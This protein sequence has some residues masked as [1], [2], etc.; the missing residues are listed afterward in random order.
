M[1]PNSRTSQRHQAFRALSEAAAATRMPPQSAPNPATF[2]D[3]A[4]VLAGRGFLASCGKHH[5]VADIAKF[6]SDRSL[7]T[8]PQR[9]D[10]DFSGIILAEPRTARSVRKNK[11][12]PRPVILVVEDDSAVR[13]PLEKFL[14]LHGFDVVSAETADAAVDRLAEQT[15]HGAVI[16]LRLAQ[17]SGRE[18]VLSIPPP[19]AVIIF[20]AV[21]D[22]S[23]RLEQM[24]PN[25]R[26]IQKPFSLVMLVETLKKMI[27]AAARNDPATRKISPARAR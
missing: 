23:G 8:A 14:A 22:E 27:D 7:V 10:A 6:A 11:M 20:S 9:A 16:D 17:G 21:P 13:G 12:T 18:V 15:V 2:D 24:R 25:T 4:E 1:L 26:L 3:C 19:T 5:P